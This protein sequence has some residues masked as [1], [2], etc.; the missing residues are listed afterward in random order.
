MITTTKV[1]NKKQFLKLVNH[2]YM[3]AYLLFLYVPMVYCNC[4]S[5]VRLNTVTKFGYQKNKEIQELIADIFSK[6]DSV[7]TPFLRTNDIF[8]VQNLAH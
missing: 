5:D 4:I 3:T 2:Q 8:F 7:L 6:V 1:K